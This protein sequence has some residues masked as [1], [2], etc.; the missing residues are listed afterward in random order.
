MRRDADFFT[1]RD[2]D[3]VYIGKRLGRSQDA[4]AALDSAGIDYA[5]EVDNY[6]GGMIFRTARAGAFF[7]VL[8]ADFE[9]A[10]DVLRARG[11]DPQDPVIPQTDQP[12]QST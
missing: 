5:I 2:M 6:V 4:E 1:D 7:Y 11:L 10:A 8:P 3:L 12:G 9:R